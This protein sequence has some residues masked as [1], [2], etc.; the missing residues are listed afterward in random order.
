MG[1][2]PAAL[3]Y[4]CPAGRGRMFSYGYGHHHTDDITYIMPLGSWD[5]RVVPDLYRR[6]YRPWIQGRAFTKGSAATLRPTLA[7]SGIC[8]CPLPQAPHQFPRLGQTSS[9]AC[10]RSCREH[11]DNALPLIS[12]CLPLPLLQPLAESTS[13]LA[14]STAAHRKKGF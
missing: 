8:R 7:A 11:R 1:W 3:W 10:P 6:S 9:P 13:S 2:S 4:S 5:Q 14:A 12:R